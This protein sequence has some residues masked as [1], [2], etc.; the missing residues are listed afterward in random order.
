MLSIIITDNPTIISL[1]KESNLAVIYPTQQIATDELISLGISVKLDGFALL[2]EAICIS[3]K[4]PYFNGK[5]IYEHVSKVSGKKFR[6]VQTVMQKAI[7]KA[8][9]NAAFLSKRQE[10]FP[11]N[12][13]QMPELLEFI[14]TMV[15]HIHHIVIERLNK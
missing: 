10:V 5:Q 14:K 15:I 13:E 6:T 4:E 2:V 8:W 11:H 12:L 9:D 3:L 1:A 7:N